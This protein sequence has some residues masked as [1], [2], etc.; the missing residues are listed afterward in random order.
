MSGLILPASAEVQLIL[1][2]YN[3]VERIM[4]GSDDVEARTVRADEYMVQVR[5]RCGQRVHDAIL[6]MLAQA[7][8]IAPPFAL[9]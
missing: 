5:A 4:H 8:Q 6:V 7:R 9:Q 1:R 3:A 2:H